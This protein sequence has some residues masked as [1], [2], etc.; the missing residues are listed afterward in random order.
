MLNFHDL[1]KVHLVTAI[2]F[3]NP[4][5]GNVWEIVFLASSKYDEM[6]DERT[7]EKNYRASF[8]LTNVYLTKKLS[9]AV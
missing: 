6:L 9:L 1:W 2:G 4:L 8:F 3:Q 7:I 5:L